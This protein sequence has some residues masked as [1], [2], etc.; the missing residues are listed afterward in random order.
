MMEEVEADM[1]AARTFMDAQEEGSEEDLPARLSVDYF[2]ARLMET[3]D[4]SSEL[5]RE[6]EPVHTLQ[7]R[8]RPRAFGDLL[9]RAFQNAWV[10]GDPARK[11]VIAHRVMAGDVGDRVG[12]GA[13]QQAIDIKRDGG[14]GRERRRQRHPVS[15][16]VAR[17]TR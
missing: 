4:G 15:R 16:Q 11:R 7:G 8:E 1:R 10:A 13:A 12:P 6:V 2:D 5:I 9:D 17:P 14:L 3:L